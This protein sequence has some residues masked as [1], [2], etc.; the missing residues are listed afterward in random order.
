MYE[1]HLHFIF[2]VHPTQEQEFLLN[3][4][5]AAGAEPADRRD[6]ST[7]SVKIINL[8]MAL[9]PLLG[10]LEGVL[11]STMTC[12]QYDGGAVA[13]VVAGD[14]SSAC[15]AGSA[16]VSARH[17]GDDGG[18]R[19]S[20]LRKDSSWTLDALEDWTGSPYQKSDLSFTSSSGEGL[21]NDVGGSASPYG[22]GK[23]TA[24]PSIARPSL[25]AGRG[26]SIDR[27]I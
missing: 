22:T 15:R 7:T 25:F 27:N 5:G 11:S 23:T 17:G 4:S 3:E 24:D 18:R 21:G 14:Y 19:P 20:Y 16:H 26:S 12:W 13:V 8:T 6:P 10:A 9:L 1:S 2:A